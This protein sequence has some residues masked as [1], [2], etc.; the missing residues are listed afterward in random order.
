MGARGNV[1]P[2][3]GGSMLTPPPPSGLMAPPA[4]AQMPGRTAPQMGGKGGGALPAAL[5]SILGRARQPQQP[6]GYSPTGVPGGP[7]ANFE[8]SMAAMRA[9][10]SG[11]RLQ[12]PSMQAP[13]IAQREAGIA[14][15]PGPADIDARIAAALAQQQ[16]QR[17]QLTSDQLGITGGGQN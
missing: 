6:L 11:P 1:P 3:S 12:A 16:A 10:Q 17:Q 2:P 9:I 7:R 4:Q 5:M 14:A 15:Q 8:N 13:W